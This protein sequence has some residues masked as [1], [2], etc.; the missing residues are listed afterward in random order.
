M[1]IDN[2]H[3]I[4]GLNGLRGL[5]CLGVFGA[6][7]LNKIIPDWQ[8]MDIDIA[9]ILGRFGIV[10]LFLLSGSVL[11]L[12][13]W[14]ALQTNQ[15]FPAPGRFWLKRI[16]RIGPAYFLCLSL[17]VIHNDHW[18]EEFGWIDIILHYTFLYN[19]TEFSFYSINSVFWI[20]A[21]FAQF[22]LIVPLLFVFS[23]RG[24]VRS[25]LS[26]IVAVF[27][28]SYLAHVGLM[29]YMSTLSPW[30]YNPEY[31]S[32]NGSVLNRSLLAHMPLFLLG[33]ITGYLFSGR[34]SHSIAGHT[35]SGPR[36]DLI[37]LTC[38]SLLIII[39]GTD[40]R[41]LLQVPYGRYNFPLI[42]IFIAIIIYYAPKGKLS[43]RLLESAPLKFIGAI[44][45][46]IFVFHYPIINFTTRHLNNYGIDIAEN[47][48]LAAL[49]VLL[50][51]MLIATLS[52]YLVERPVLRFTRRWSKLSASR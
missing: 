16:A 1:S 48:S 43:F 29:A 15:S 7:Y 37:I 32:A 2:K 42:P 21:H 27:F 22:Y 49:L 14:R 35:N 19:Y 51:T 41:N 44:S 31:L 28:V 47:W 10:T 33:V 23:H 50:I 38:L 24:G 11:S 8:L 18:K 25:A 9:N 52:Y 20:L 39:L 17:L 40:I 13:F 6:N 30:P 4:P 46:G 45:Y 34:S 5:A 3:I 26:T 12:P 36:S